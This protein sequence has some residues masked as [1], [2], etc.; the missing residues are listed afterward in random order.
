MT[1]LEFFLADN[2]AVDERYYIEIYMKPG[3]DLVFHNSGETNLIKWLVSEHVEPLYKLTQ[4]EYDLLRAC[5]E[6]TPLSHTSFFTHDILMKMKEYGYYKQIENV[7][8]FIG[9][10]LENCEVIS[11][12]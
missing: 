7:D 4:F 1:N 11:D 10:I 5:D 12:D 9:C 3:Y 6:R 8:F 2:D